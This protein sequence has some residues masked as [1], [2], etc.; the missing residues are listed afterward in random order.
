[1][2]AFPFILEKREGK[3]LERLYV[4]VGKK[5][6]MKGKENNFAGPGKGLNDKE[7]PDR[8]D[9]EKLEGQ[10]KFR[11]ENKTQGIDR[12]ERETEGK[13]GEGKARRGAVMRMK[14]Q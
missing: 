10:R 3:D 4:G 2:V 6:G 1:M 11:A 9:K 8:I 14:G 7:R 13:E 12:G 5:R